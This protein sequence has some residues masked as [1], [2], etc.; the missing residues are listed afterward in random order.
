MQSGNAV[1]EIRNTLQRFQ[2]G[3][4]VRDP[5]SLD[6][7]MGLFEQNSET[8]LI[9]IGASVRGGNEWFQGS[10]QIREIIASDWQYWG[11]VRIDVEGAK[12]SVLDR[13]AWLTTSGEL[14][15]TDTF[16]QALI[17]YLEQMKELIE[18]ENLDLDER[19][20]E[21]T[22]FGMRRLRER[23]KGKGY[24]WPFVLSAVLVNREAAWRFHTIHW[25]MPVD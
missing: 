7:F 24:G 15:Q 5:S 18:K 2:D 13:V 17:F 10:E 21:A 4:I 16:D 12:I 19:L 8:E 22:H 23:Q 6:E 3:Y 20:L 25:S 14:V 1:A 9:G 11:D